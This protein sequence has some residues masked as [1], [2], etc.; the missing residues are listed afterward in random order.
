MGR[1]RYH[2]IWN[3]LRYKFP[4]IPSEKL[5]TL[6][7]LVF[8]LI[9]LVQNPD[10]LANERENHVMKIFDFFI[11]A[12]LNELDSFIDFLVENYQITKADIKEVFLS[13]ISTEDI[14]QFSY[15]KNKLYDF[16]LNIYPEER[17]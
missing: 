5:D 6:P 16:V 1:E 11:E 4:N 7:D 8:Q 9:V 2:E 3:M 14:D 17:N 10:A 15:E 13:Q 12:K